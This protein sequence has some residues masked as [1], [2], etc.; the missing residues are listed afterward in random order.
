MPPARPD[1]HAE[2]SGTKNSNLGIPRSRSDKARHAKLAAELAEKVT[3]KNKEDVMAR[4]IGQSIDPN[5]ISNKMMREIDFDGIGRITSFRSGVTLATLNVLARNKIKPLTE[6]HS[7]FAR[8]IAKSGRGCI[9][10]FMHA[11]KGHDDPAARALVI[12]VKEFWLSGKL[13][14]ASVAGFFQR[15]GARDDLAPPLKALADELQTTSTQP[16]VATQFYDNIYGR[17]FESDF[18]HELVKNPPA[19]LLNNTAK[20]GDAMLDWVM[21]SIVPTMPEEDLN[22]V[23]GA[24]AAKISEDMR[25]W[26]SETPEVR[27]FLENPT[28]DN[29]APMYNKVDDGFDAI[30]IPYL[31]ARFMIV[32]DDFEIL[33][34]WMHEANTNYVEVVEATR[35]VD[36]SDVTGGD[37]KG[38]G[39]GLPHHPQHDPLPGFQIG[40]NWAIAKEIQIGEPTAFETNSLKYGH[41]VACSVSGS[42]NIM[43]HFSQHLAENDPE[44]S[45]QQAQLCT[46]MFALFDGGHSA[47]EVMVVA[48]ALEEE[49]WEQDKDMD[50]ILNDRREFTA[51]YILDYND[52]IK[53]GLEDGTH[54]EIRQALDSAFA[55]TV[56]YYEALR[57]QAD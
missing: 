21:D 14:V 11:L 47:N 20:I 55:T 17:K 25:P 28:L 49:P 45:Q 57:P 13:D 53:L 37:F 41:P 43:A 38:H 46:L 15:A 30:K 48:K 33:P 32:A 51:N 3:E 26:F 23:L 39:L 5:K 22:D 40:T 16:K 7:P 44:F 27:A 12:E 1:A 10:E 34:T 8:D 19:R 2:G 56:K 52:I 4:L 31:C 24:V 36:F 6:S 29:F 18:A 54:D 35:S 50:D 42:A 9:V